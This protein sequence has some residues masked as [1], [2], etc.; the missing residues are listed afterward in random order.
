VPEFGDYPLSTTANIAERAQQLRAELSYHDHRY[1]VL[2]DPELSDASYD[3][4]YRELKTLEAEHPELASADSPTQRVAGLRLERFSEAV[5]RRPMLSIDNAMNE[6]EPRRFVEKV[7]QDLGLSASQ[8]Q[9]TGEPKYDGLSCALIYENGVLVQ[10]GTRGD[11]ITGEDVTAQVRTI[12]SVPLRLAGAPIVGRVEVR[13]EVVLGRKEFLALN[14]EQDARKEKR[15][16]NPRNAAAG[17]LRQLDPQITASRNLKFFAYGFGEC[18]GFTAPDSQ[19]AQLQAMQ[20]LGFLVDESARLLTG[21]T[22]VQAHFEKVAAARATMGFDIDGVVF[23]LDNGAYREKLGFTART[24]RWAIAYKFPPE[25]AETLVEKI[26]IQV[27]RTGVLTPVARL[28]PVFVG[29]VTVSNATLHN[30]DEIERLG[31]RV[32]D[33]VI[34]SRG[35]DVIPGIVKV[36]LSKRRPDSVPFVM[37]TTCPECG[38]AVLRQGDEVALRCSAGLECP[39]QR[40][41]ALV[42]YASRRAM[43]IEGLGDGIVEKLL[44]AGCITRLESLYRLRPEDLE[45]L[46]GFAK[47]SANKLINAIA[48]SKG[49]ELARFIFALG[50]PGIGEI[51]AKDL[52]SAFS[53]CTAFRAASPTQLLGVAGL[54]PVCAQSITFFFTHSGNAAQAEQLAAFVAPAP[55]L[56]RVAGGAPLLGKTFV[57]TGTLSV[58]R[59][60]AAAWIEA[61]GGKISGSVSKKTSVL[62]AGEAA[63]SKLEKARELNVEIWDEA[64]L[65]AETGN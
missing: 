38:S 50:I 10:A 32:N 15:F 54:G 31:L 52:A 37:P 65:R 57:L 53:T 58:S 21:V 64:K 40:L 36:I 29:G 51:T 27:G 39:A 9:F 62:V 12:R 49:R 5:H 47:V 3:T 22:E 17:S 46:P 30:E 7:A 1:Y 55:F 43:D 6:V 44:N 20:S 8:L 56:T 28:K 24:P 60:A 35:G 2:D 59:D 48:A 23:T 42:H 14:A 13:G 41:A 61:S 16:V 11:G 4:L 25:E 18:D 26:D 45:T 34:L 33:T 19:L 63:G